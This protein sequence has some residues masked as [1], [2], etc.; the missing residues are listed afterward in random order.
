MNY[1]P[2]REKV[3]GHRNIMNTEHPI[4]VEVRRFG[5]KQWVVALVCNGIAESSRTYTTRHDALTAYEAYGAMSRPGAL[6][7]IVKGKVS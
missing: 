2:L 6:A 3:I 7:A 4:W 1:A 5:P